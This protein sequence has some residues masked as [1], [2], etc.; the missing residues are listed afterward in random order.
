VE[1]ELR[2]QVARLGLGDRVRFCGLLPS[3]A[4]REALAR[5]HLFVAPYVETAV[6]DK[7]GIPTAIL[8]AMASG[9][10]V[11]AT[12]AGSI[13]E[14]I[15]DGASGRLV[16]E[17]D[18][19]AFAAAAAGLLADPDLRRRLAAGGAARARSEFASARREPL[20]AERIRGLLAR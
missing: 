6:G 18:P 15:V 20:L 19:H 8:E 5:A 7:D 12:P 16:A 17:C 2:E 13:P 4:V 14:A 1:R 11:L 3:E 9:V 10:P